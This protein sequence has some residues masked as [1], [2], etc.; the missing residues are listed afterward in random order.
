MFICR[1]RMQDKIIRNIAVANRSFENVAKFRYFGTT[2]ENQNSI[3]YDIKTRLNSDNA[4]YQSVQNL[5]SSRLLSK[6]IKIIM[7]KITILS[8]VLY[9]C[10]TWSVTFREQHR[11]WML[12]NRVLRNIHWA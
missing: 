8:V 1:H 5:M 12:E 4:Y 11:L 6:N 10:E 2:V 7:Y 9:G 3:N